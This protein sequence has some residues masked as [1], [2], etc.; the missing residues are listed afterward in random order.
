MAQ[1]TGMTL[2]ISLKNVFDLQPWQKMLPLARPV[3]VGI[4][5]NMF[6]TFY[7]ICP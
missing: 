7:E 3:G 5:S 6:V 1:R 2:G 4:I